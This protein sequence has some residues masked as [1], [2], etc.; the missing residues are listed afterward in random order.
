MLEPCDGKLSRTVLRGEG[1]R[2]APALPGVPMINRLIQIAL[3]ILLII[4][5]V[6]L[7]LALAFNGTVGETFVNY[8]FFLSSVLIISFGF[9]KII[10][11][12]YTIS[13]CLG[14][15]SIVL[16]LPMIWQRFNF[17]YETDKVGLKFDIW[18]VVLIITAIIIRPTKSVKSEIN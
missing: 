14:I 3:G 5:G 15:I 12:K 8:S 1:S 13:V 10:K 18:I 17:A 11:N 4:L 9:S 7:L 16:Y 6:F 2:K